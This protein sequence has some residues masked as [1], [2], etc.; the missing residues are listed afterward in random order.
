MGRLIMVS[1]KVLLASTYLQ[2]WDMCSLCHWF[3]VHVLC[4]HSQEQRAT[5]VCKASLRDPT[6]RMPLVDNL[7]REASERGLLLFLCGEG[8]GSGAA[9]S[10]TQPY[11]SHPTCFLCR[12]TSMSGAETTVCTT[13][14]RRQMQTH[15]MPAV[16]SS[17]PTLAGCLY[18]STRTS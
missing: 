15:T 5:A 3:P 17:S 11:F 7:F 12:T 9:G 18:A 2:L 1:P 10:N 14:T 16:A 13:N 4:G 8:A 6:L